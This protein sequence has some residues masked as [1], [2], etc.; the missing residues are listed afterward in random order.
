MT[1]GITQACAEDKC[2]DIW[3]RGGILDRLGVLEVVAIKETRR[4]KRFDGL[5][6]I[7]V[8]GK[9]HREGGL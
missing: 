6:L 3:V 5:E 8:V 2:R 7:M 9:R 1:T 4:V